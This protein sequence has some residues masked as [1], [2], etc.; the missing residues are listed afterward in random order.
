MQQFYLFSL[1]TFDY[2]DVIIFY[3]SF[4]LMYFEKDRYDAMNTKS[5]IAAWNADFDKF[6]ET[7]TRG[8]YRKYFFGPKP[9]WKE[10]ESSGIILG[11]L[12]CFLFGAFIVPYLGNRAGLDPLGL[13]IAVSV[14]VLGGFLILIKGF[15]KIK[16]EK[17]KIYKAVTDEEF[18]RY[19][20][21]D[22]LGLKNKAKAFLKE[23]IADRTCSDN[24]DSV[25]PFILCSAE[26]Y[27]SNVNLPLMVKK[28]DDNLIRA[29]NLFFMLIYP[30]E[31]SCYIYTS[32]VNLFD[33]TAK[34]EH[35]YDCKYSSI[36]E[37]GYEDITFTTVTQ[38][39]QE[40]L[41]RTKTLFIKAKEGNTSRVSVDIV[42]YNIV[43]NLGGYFDETAALKAY[44]FLN[45]QL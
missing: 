24:I 10:R 32:Y 37:V 17:N 21:Y 18:D 11:A 28:G 20:Q 43:Q 13:K 23:N 14:L 31:E 19:F 15:F 3:I 26:N 34:F 29:S 30:F 42:D 36:G 33:G 16:E 39:G 35:A 27:S 8:R 12:L 7:I 22:I 41:M 2:D 44:E 5:Q 9:S 1:L 40:V 4:M 6:Q 45:S 25:E 38:K